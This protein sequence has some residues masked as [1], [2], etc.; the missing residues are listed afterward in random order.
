MN[1]CMA[2]QFLVSLHDLLSSSKTV[3]GA[4]IEFAFFISSPSFKSTLNLGE[5]QSGALNE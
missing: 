5:K 3:A 2:I 1:G 4:N